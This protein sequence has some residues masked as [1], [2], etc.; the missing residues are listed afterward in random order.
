MIKKKRKPK[1]IYIN[2]SIGGHNFAGMTTEK[3]KAASESNDKPSIDLTVIKNRKKIKDA[4][5]K[6]SQNRR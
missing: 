5:K 4:W 3:E 6:S 2:E 1:Y